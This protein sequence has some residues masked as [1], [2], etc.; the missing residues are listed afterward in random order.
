MMCRV[1]CFLALL[2]SVVSLCV[3][4][5]T[6][7]D[8]ALLPDDG[9]CT[10]GSGSSDAHHCR[11]GGGGGPDPTT[12]GPSRGED[13]A[14]GTC[15]EGA[16]GDSS[17]G[18][19]NRSSSAGGVAAGTGPHP[20]PP[21]RDSA[22]LTQDVS[23]DQGARLAQDTQSEPRPAVTAAEPPAGVSG[24]TDAPSGPAAPSTPS[25]SPGEGSSSESSSVGQTESATTSTSTSPTNSS[26]ESTGDS[27][28]GTTENG[29]TP[30]GSESV[31]N[32]SD[33]DSTDTTTTTTTT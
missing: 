29:I 4:A 33:A 24:D 27:D 7:S 18:T 9:R 1:F 8:P 32:P 23:A 20:Q 2:L 25:S 31:N 22:S 13:G 19:C 3:T 30:A 26:T 21:A 14:V 6:G 28:G 5:E 17:D 10:E 16:A 11:R 12:G 15:P